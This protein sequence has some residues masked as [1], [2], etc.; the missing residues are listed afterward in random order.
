MEPLLRRNR[1][2]AGGRRGRFDYQVHQPRARRTS[3][4][5]RNEV[6]RMGRHGRQGWAGVQALAINEVPTRGLRLPT[7]APGRIHH[8]GP[9]QVYCTMQPEL[10]HREVEGAP[11]GRHDGQTNGQISSRLSSG[12][13]SRPSIPGHASPREYGRPAEL[14]LGGTAA[15]APRPGQDLRHRPERPAILPPARRRGLQQEE[16]HHLLSVVPRLMA[17]FGR[18]L[19]LGER[20]YA[21]KP[22]LRYR[23]LRVRATGDRGKRYDI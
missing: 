9:A 14:H 18:R 17:L 8:G 6:Q 4:P 16:M 3:E 2:T 19:L 13:S 1:H 7:G 22:A 11:C 15:A 20:M 5:G 21:E 10:P 12:H 23:L